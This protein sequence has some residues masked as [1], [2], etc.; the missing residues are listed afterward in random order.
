MGT[1]AIAS[2]VT[3]IAAMLT[4]L[5]VSYAFGT[6]RIAIVQGYNSCFD[7]DCCMGYG[8]N[9]AGWPANEPWVLNALVGF[10]FVGALSVL[11]ARFVWFLFEPV[12]FLLATAGRPLLDGIWTMALI[13]WILKA[14]TLRIGGSKAYEGLGIPVA[15]GFVV[16][17][18]ISTF[19]GGAI[20]V[21]MFFVTF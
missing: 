9:V 11:H 6:R 13:A 17:V 12:G 5:S 3:P 20:G 4:A 8:A 16:G 14:L 18:I 1:W 15:S 7:I 2:I 19:I 21:V 10:L